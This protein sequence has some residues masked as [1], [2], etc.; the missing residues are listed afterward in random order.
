[1]NRRRLAQDV[2]RVKKMGDRFFEGNLNCR[3]LAQDVGRFKKMGSFFG[4]KFEPPEA[5]P[6]R[7]QDLKMGVV[8]LLE[9]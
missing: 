8:F 4:G 3:R 9:I 6:R 2:G 5:C 1:M 7:W